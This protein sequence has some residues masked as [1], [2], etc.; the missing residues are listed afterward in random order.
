MRG[1]WLVWAAV[2]TG[3][4][5]WGLY[6]PPAPRPLLPLYEPE[7]PADLGA[8]FDPA[9]CVTIRGSVEWAGA[10]P[11]VPPIDLI[12]AQVSPESRKKYPNPNSPRVKN[13]RLAD[14][15][16]YLTAVDPRRSSPWAHP[17]VTVEVTR[18]AIVVRQGDRTGRAGVVRRGGGVNLVAHEVALHSIRARGAEFFTQMLPHP[19]RPVTRQFDDAGIVELSSGSGYYWLRGYLLVSDHPYAT[20]TGPDGAFQLPQVPDGQY[21]LVCWVPNWQ[22]ERLENDPEWVA[23]VRLYFRPGIEKRHK[24]VVTAGAVQDVRVTFSA[25]DFGPPGQAP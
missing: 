20:V 11:T 19:D 2:V 1:R 12:H 7:P 18:P 24:V 8:A 16:V 17:P 9:R 4:V 21:D 6:T 14:A 25:A 10:V 22:I 23:P 5:V 3:L 13:G 15:I